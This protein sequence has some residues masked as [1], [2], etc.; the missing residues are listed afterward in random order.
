MIEGSNQI[1]YLFV[2]TYFNDCFSSQMIWT[3]NWQHKTLC[4]H[5]MIKS[6]CGLMVVTFSQFGFNAIIVLHKYLFEVTF[7]L[8][9]IPIIKDNK[10]RIQ[11]TCQ[12]GVWKNL[13]WTLLTYLWHQQ[14]QTSIR[15]VAG[16]IIVFLNRECVLD[17]VLIMN[18]L[19]RSTLT[20]TQKFNVRFCYFGW[21]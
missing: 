11:V 4:I 18:G 2:V 10:L 16:S 8:A 17:C 6:I 14:F 20:I 21:E 15:S 9:L 5:S 19:K 3:Y 1:D 7:E 12:L 13:E